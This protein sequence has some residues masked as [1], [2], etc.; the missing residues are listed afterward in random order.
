MRTLLIV[1]AAWLAAAAIP[2]HASDEA[3]IRGLE[4]VW[5]NAHLQGNTDA[6]ASLWA[7]D[8][9]IVVPKMEPM[10]KPSSLQFWK[11]VPIKFTKY[12]SE[13][14]SVRVYGDT[15]IANGTV[16]RSRKFGDRP[17]MQDSWYF[18]KVYRRHGS[19]WQ[20]VSYHAS[21]TP[22]QQKP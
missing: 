20:V 13:L 19:G 11:K 14:S 12:S 15:A 16:H 7:D 22:E 10:D 5:N 3:T 17:E 4:D 2:A 18:T 9:V 8:L 1:F 6:L 21:E